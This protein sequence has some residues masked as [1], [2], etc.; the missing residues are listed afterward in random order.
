MTHPGYK[1]ALTNALRDRAKLERTYATSLEELDRLIY[2]LEIILGERD[3]NPSNVII[4]VGTS[5]VPFIE[6]AVESEPAPDVK[7]SSPKA[8]ASGLTK[9]FKLAVGDMSPKHTFY[10]DELYEVL[11]RITGRRVGKSTFYKYLRCHLDDRTV[12]RLSQGVYSRAPSSGDDVQA[13]ARH[14]RESSLSGHVRAFIARLPSDTFSR[15][16][17]HDI[18]F[19]GERISLD[20]I[21]A[22]LELLL[23]SLS[24][25]RVRRG[26]YR[27]VGTYW[28]THKGGT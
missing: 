7:A 12:I 28:E 9:A 6:S 4:D 11:A 2:G 24:I 27:K 17:L 22:T 8:V 16:G 13:S 19:N 3:P 1:V 5:I 26:V 18:T 25:E 14:L 21:D 23:R 10:V 15:R 20:V